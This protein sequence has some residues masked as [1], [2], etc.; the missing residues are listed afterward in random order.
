MKIMKLFV[1]SKETDSEDG[2][3]LY[4]ETPYE[5]GIAIETALKNGYTD[6]RISPAN[7]KEIAEN[8]LYYGTSLQIG[9]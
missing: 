4:I 9:D 1:D 2:Y 5:M 7:K 6:I 8:N 3:E